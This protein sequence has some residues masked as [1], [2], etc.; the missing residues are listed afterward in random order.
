[1]QAHGLLDRAFERSFD[2]GQAFDAL[3]FPLLYAEH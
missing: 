2:A 1:M 3:S